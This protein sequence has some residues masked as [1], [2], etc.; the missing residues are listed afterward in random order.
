MAKAKK[1]NLLGSWAFLIGVVLA[2]IFAFVTMTEGI[3]LT[4]FVL[5][6]LIGL[7]NITAKQVQP[8]LLA[9]VALVIV[10]SLGSGALVQIGWV[11]NMLNNMLLLF[12]PATIIVALK[13]VFELAKK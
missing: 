1:D 9:A 2:L 4:L 13:S 3:M 6:L 7:L 11:L 5:G 8:F 10:S 12:V